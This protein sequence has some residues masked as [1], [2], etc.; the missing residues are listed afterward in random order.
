MEVHR[1]VLPT[2][3]YYYTD[4]DTARVKK[5]LHRIIRAIPKNPTKHVTE[6]MECVI[7]FPYILDGY[8]G[9]KE[10]LQRKVVELTSVARRYQTIE[11]YQKLL[12]VLDKVNCTF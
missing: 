2:T 8:K 10:L 5:E 9:F 6:L 3:I 4:K 7:R 12:V 11:K 1:A